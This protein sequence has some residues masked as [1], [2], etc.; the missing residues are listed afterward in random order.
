MTTLTAIVLAAG[1]GTRMKSKRAK[2]LHELAGRP[3]LHHVLDTA[4]E[5]GVT[6][7][8]V[9]VGF[10]AE[11]VE[12]SLGAFGPRVR[13]ARQDQ[14]LG[15]GHAVKCAL[16]ALD[17]NAG[18]VMIL[19]GDTPLV[20]AAD[21]RGL[22]SALDESAAPLALLTCK[23]PDPTGYGRILRDDAG[24]VT[25]IREHRDC[26]D[27][28]RAIDE[29]NPAMYL[30][31]ADFLRRAVEL[32]EPN[33][34]QGELYFTDVVATAQKEGG[35]VGVV[36][37]SH[38]TL[39]GINDRAQLDAAEVVAYAK[40]ADGL[41]R[42]GVTLRSSARVDAGVVVEADATIEHGAVLRGA[43][44][45][46]AG[47]VID[48][49]AVLTDVVVEAGARVLPYTVASRST[50]GSGAQIG[51]FSHLR[52]ESDVREGAHIGNFVET[53][54]TIVHKGA[55]ANHL[56]YLGDGEIGEGANVGAGTIFCNYDGFKKHKTEIGPGAFI[57]SDSQ[58]VA[59]VKI[60]AGAYVAT[61]TTVTKDV[62]DDAL[63]IARLK[64]ENKE[65]YASR[66]R[67]RLKAGSGK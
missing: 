30:A 43:T 14:Q 23:V 58:L 31:R 7:A 10:D 55:K 35:A 59:P 4:F 47:A 66:L 37:R 46:K 57:G 20:E 53:K 1:Q 34:A 41:R 8:I 32:L 67:A 45:V 21:L 6:D 15:T 63:A 19:C 33:N 11:N 24:N 44:V 38:E 27:R 36:A 2:V 3:I 12:R 42:A 22:A 60:G 39:V 49:G 9:V 62:P 18:R 29:V 65:G 61:G 13:T 48:V 5:A 50:I 52:P 54:K 28:E 51:P 56:A 40:I 17:A 26:N 16:P 25:G 64:Q